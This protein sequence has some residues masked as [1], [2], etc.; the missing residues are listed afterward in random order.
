MK[1]RGSTASVTQFHLFSRLAKVADL[2]RFSQFL[3]G[4]RWALKPYDL[5]SRFDHSTVLTRSHPL[6]LFKLIF[7]LSLACRQDFEVIT[8]C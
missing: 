6:V 2:K 8:S 4:V 7:G 3:V 5:R 1:R